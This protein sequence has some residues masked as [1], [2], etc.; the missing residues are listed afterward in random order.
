MKRFSQLWMLASLVGVL[1][2]SS[3][4]SADECGAKGQKPCPL[5]GWMEENVQGPLDDGKLDKVAAA[6]EK[7]A[8][9]APDKEWDKG[10]EG[11]SALAKA[12]AAAAKAGDEKAAKKSCK[13]CHK[14]FRKD[15]KAKHRMAAPP[16]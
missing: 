12:G 8:S 2:L 5:Q 16:K 10:A 14:K 3:V 15:Y 11:W 13:T 4:A 1:G 6:L 9:I 7:V